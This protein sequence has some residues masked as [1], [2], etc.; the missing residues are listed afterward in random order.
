[1]AYVK[2]EATVAQAWFSLHVNGVVVPDFRDRAFAVVCFYFFHCISIY[3]RSYI[4]HEYFLKHYF[5]SFV[6]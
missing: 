1:M 2:K 5:M 3:G 4:K 6:L